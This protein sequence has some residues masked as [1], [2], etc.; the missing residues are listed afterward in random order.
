M[1]LGKRGAVAAWR[2]RSL[3]SA[4]SAFG[5]H[6]HT[7]ALCMLPRCKTLS[8]S[9]NASANLQYFLDKET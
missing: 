7:Q 5:L 1:L 8:A 6:A 2:L 3:Y 9:P 4:A